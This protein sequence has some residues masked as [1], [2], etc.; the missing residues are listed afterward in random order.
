MRTI[1]DQRGRMVLA[2]LDLFINSDRDVLFDSFHPS[3]RAALEQS[4]DKRD[5]KPEALKARDGRY[6]YLCVKDGF[7]YPGSDR[8]RSLRLF[9]CTKS[10]FERRGATPFDELKPS[11]EATHLLMLRPLPEHLCYYVNTAEQIP[12]LYR[13]MTPD[14]MRMH[15][16]DTLCAWVGPSFEPILLDGADPIEKGL[17]LVMGHASHAAQVTRDKIYWSRPGFLGTWTTRLLRTS[18]MLEL[19][20]E[21][22]SLKPGCVDLSGEDV[23]DDRITGLVRSML[24]RDQCDDAQCVIDIYQPTP[25]LAASLTH[26]VQSYRQRRT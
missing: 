22:M 17:H 21:H 6:A 25:D 11:S 23:H 15:M 20:R 24:S 9:F 8:L 5:M 7:E 10:W 18:M 2:E 26:M 3:V 4:T 19:E 16:T 14:V 1:Y 12:E 13:G